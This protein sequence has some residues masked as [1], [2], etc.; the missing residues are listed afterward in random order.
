MAEAHPVAFQWVIEAKKR[1]A[2]VIHIDPR[3][4]RT[5]ANA[6]RHIPLRSGSDVIL[7]GAVINHVLTHDLWFEE[8][9]RTFTNISTIVTEDYVDSED[10]DGVFSGFDPETGQY[11]MKT[12]AYEGSE[13]DL[14]RGLP[15]R[16]ETL[17]HPRCVYQIL[18]RHYA[19][20]TPEMVEEYCGIERADFDYLV[21]Q[22]V[23]NSGRERTTVFAYALGWTQQ[24]GGSQMIRTSAVLQLLMG[25]VGRPGSGIMAMRGHAN[26]QGGTDLPTLFH[27]LPGYLPMPKVGQDDLASYARAVGRKEQKGFWA[28]AETYTVNLLKAWWGDHAT[29]ENDY[30]FDYLP[31][32][33]GAHSTYQTLER[34]LDHAI[35]GYF[36]LGQNPVVGSANG[37]LQRRGMSNLKWL[38]VRDYYMI[39][40]ATWWKDGPEVESGELRSE[41]IGTEVFFMPAA[42]HMEKSGSFTQ[43]QR[44]LQWRDQGATPPDDAISE[45]Q[46]IHE[47][48]QRIREKL[49]DS[50]DPRDRPLL[51]LTWD[52]PL[53]EHGEPDAEAVLMEINGRYL[54]GEKAGEPLP[55][56]V[57][58]K[59]DGSTSGGCWIYSGVFKDGVNQAR[60][61]KPGAEQGLAALEWGWAWPMNRRILYNRASADA[62]GRPWSER[63][64]HVWWDEEQ[65]KW[66]GNDVPDFPVAKRPDDPGDPTKGGAAAL[67]G[68]D[69]FIMQPDGRAWLFAPSGLVDGPLPTHYEG[70]ESRV[71]NPLYPQQHTPTGLHPERGKDNLNAPGTNPGGDVYPYVFTTYRLTEH[72]T[73]G[74]MSR[75]VPYLSELQ[76]ELYCE[77]SPELAGELGLEPNGW[78]TI[79]TA[80]SA[81]EAKVMIT[82][83][84]TP[85]RI[86]DTVIHT[87]GL[88]YHWARGNQAVVSGDAV[89]DLIGMNLDANTQIQ[90]S[91]NNQCAIIAGRRPRGE[92]LAALVREYQLKAGIVTE[93]GGIR[94]Y[95]PQMTHNA[96]E[97]EHA[98]DI[99]EGVAASAYAEGGAAQGTVTDAPSNNSQKGEDR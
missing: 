69:A 21:E 15:Q 37:R 61:R 32:L 25:N 39:E 35:D 30:C 87:V 70:P 27:I 64:K 79:I 9:V 52:Y 28:N 18:K 24:Q 51:D 29:A 72:H 60:R 71:P 44:M 55:G 22:I 98:A 3:F 73:A 85:L 14:N 81:I 31:R 6:D 86:G 5:S 96:E 93:D 91:K 2:K 57:D 11:D 97:I 67:S 92:A 13:E 80:R 1:G 7:L 26:I 90:N 19:R 50:T 23:R 12:W 41:D 89:N 16:D 36:I 10:G 94:E 53:D 77:I 59:G 76:P 42:N 58:M 62:Q 43:T 65:G 56:F 68:T 95:T 40:S 99:P 84:M 66:V 83:R 20:Y 75:F 4:T 46:F 78:M 82:E 54:T 48:G 45:L 47:L 88:P 34:M 49:K 33:T 63:K 74:G 38:V 8:Y 17:Q